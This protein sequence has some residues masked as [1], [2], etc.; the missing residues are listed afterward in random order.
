MMH[1][2]LW[3][4]R[5]LSKFEHFKN[6]GLGEPFHMEIGPLGFRDLILPVPAI[7][8]S[9]LLALLGLVKLLQPR[10]G[11]NVNI[12]PSHPYELLGHRLGVSL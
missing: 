9:I 6:V 2:K 11:R 1:S 10:L 7:W 3:K 12:L 8:E 5:T 4:V